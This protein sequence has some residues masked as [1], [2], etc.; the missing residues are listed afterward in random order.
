MQFLPDVYVTCDACKGLRYNRDTLDIR[1]K[2]KTIADVLNL[3]V[4]EALTF[5]S[6]VPAVRGKLQTLT[7]V[8][9]G[10][11]KLGRQANTLSGG[12]AQ[13]VKL[14][15]ELSKR[16]TGRT[17]YLLDEPTTG[18]HFVD[19]EMLLSVLNRLVD[20]GN[21]VVVI[22]HHL[23]VI[24]CADYLVDLGPE[25]GDQGG[26][27]VIAGPPET[28]ACCKASHTGRYLR[29]LLPEFDRGSLSSR[30]PG[31]SSGPDDRP[32]FPASP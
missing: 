8:G 29:E 13:R 20:L 4:E 30:G 25:G 12:E 17:L 31:V 15:R 18:L 6:N 14:A 19:I 3:T 32:G 16:G 22:E 26:R 1:Y 10:Y 9:L 23:D 21:T 24:K 7:E 27:V 2:G 11:L 28:V 5:F